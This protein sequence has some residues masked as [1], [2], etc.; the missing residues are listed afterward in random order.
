MTNAAPF[1]LL[2]E[3]ATPPNA[4]PSHLTPRGQNFV[5]PDGAIVIRKGITA[6]TLPKRFATG[7]GDEALRYMD[8]WASEGGNEVRAF[9]RVDWDGPPGSGVES[10]WQYDETACRE[11]IEQAAQRGLRVFL[12]ANTGP[13]GNGARDMAAHLQR[14]DELCL[15]YDNAIL[16]GY[17]EP[18]QNGG[19]ELVQQ[20]LDLYTPR[21]SGWSSGVYDP[22]PYTLIKQVG[23][24]PPPNNR[25]IY[26]AQPD[27]RVG[28]SM[29]YHSPRKDEWSRCFKDIYEYSNGGG[30]N[31]Q[32][33]PPYLGPIWHDE[34]PQVEQT[35]RDRFRTDAWEDVADDWMAFAAGSAFFGCGALLHGNPQFQQCIVPTDPLILDCVRA[36]IRGFSWVPVQVYSGY[37]GALQ[38]TPSDNLGSRRYQRKGADGRTYEICVRPF[39]FRAV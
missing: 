21:S 1:L 33:S 15:A 19:H 29:G 5:D 14:V 34:P 24:T 13:F 16:D 36:F 26:A 31:D 22:T 28:P 32:F 30:P 8:W 11:T 27:A 4:K 18:Q 9:S 10:G 23:L 20:I 39:S 12:T 2:S 17:N 38:P 7:R 37:S 3:S 25:P 6:F 35:I